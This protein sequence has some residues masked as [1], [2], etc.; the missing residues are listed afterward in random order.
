MPAF[1]KRELLKPAPALSWAKGTRPVPTLDGMTDEQ[2]TPELLPA[3]MTILRPGGGIVLPAAG[4]WW[5]A[6]TDKADKVKPKTGKPDTLTVTVSVFA[7]EGWAV[8]GTV[9]VTVALDVARIPSTADPIDVLNRT[10]SAGAVLMVATGL[11]P[12]AVHGPAMAADLIERALVPIEVVTRWPGSAMMTAPPLVVGAAFD[13][14][15]T[16][17]AKHGY[18]LD[19]W[20]PGRVQCYPPSEEWPTFEIVRGQGVVTPEDGAPPL[21]GLRLA[22]LPVALKMATHPKLVDRAAGDLI[23]LAKLTDTAKLTGPKVTA[24]GT[25]SFWL[26]WT[27]SDDARAPEWLADIKI[28]IDQAGT[29]R[30]T[31]KYRASRDSKAH[32]INSAAQ[33]RRWLESFDGEDHSQVK[34]VIGPMGSNRKFS[35][36][37]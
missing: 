29:V 28:R 27:I 11:E 32:T 1:T 9:A 20:A 22:M 8:V 2:T 23:E 31:G 26:E 13:E 14:Y 7:A 37:V 17:L 19:R 18:T 4:R 33:I 5:H 34:K 15:L 3:E 25:A 36:A 16:D 35:D 30:Y 12:K 10:A 21:N 24:R 6:K